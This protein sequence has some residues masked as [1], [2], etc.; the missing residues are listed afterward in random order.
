[1][2]KKI[3]LIYIALALLLAA[4]G[5]ARL[6]GNAVAGGIGVHARG[7]AR[8]LRGTHART[9]RRVYR[10]LFLRNWCAKR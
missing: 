4:C 7:N 8:T 3:V 9:G 1:M 5:D 2:M 6:D 10:L